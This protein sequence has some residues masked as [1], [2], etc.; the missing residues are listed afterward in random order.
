[1]VKW[2]RRFLVVNLFLFFTS[3]TNAEQISRPNEFIPP[4]NQSVQETIEIRL[5]T[6]SPYDDIFAWFGHSALE[7]INNKTGKSHAFNFGGFYFGVENL[8]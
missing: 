7:V 6:F 8:L 4:S 1:M 2:F 3:I 5:I